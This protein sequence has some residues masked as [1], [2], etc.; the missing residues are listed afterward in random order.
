MCVALLAVAA[1]AGCGSAV[2][3]QASGSD[4]R[5]VVRLATAADLTPPTLFAGGASNRILIGQVYETLVT[6]P[7][8]GLDPQPAL[9]TS[10]KLAPDG[11]SISLELR[12]NVEFSN[13]VEFT[14]KDVEASIKA[15]AEPQWTAQMLLTAA[16]ITGFESSNPHQ[17]T[18]RFA[19]PLSN[20]FDLLDQVPM[21][22]AKSIDQVAAGKAFIG[23]GPFVLASWTPNSKLVF[24]PNDRYW[25][26]PPTIDEVV[27]MVGVDSQSQVAQLRAGQLD[28]ILDP[29]SRE[30]DQ[31][32]SDSQFQVLALNGTEQQTYLGM[33]VANAALK[34]VRLREAIALAID[35]QRIADDVYGGSAVPISLPWPKYSP[36]YSAQQNAAFAQDIP[37][38]KKL[39]AEIGDV[40]TLPIQYASEFPNSAELAQIIQADLKEI[41]VS[42][43][44]EP[45]QLAQFAGLLVEGKFSAL[46][47]INHEFAQ[48]TPSTLAVSAYPFNAEKNASNFDSPEYKAAANGA[49][50]LTDSDGPEAKKAYARLDDA[51]LKG[52]FLT[53]LVGV[54]PRVVAA[55]DV[56]GITWGK[57]SPELHLAKVSFAD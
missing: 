50:E 16:A 17:I 14:A 31:L 2:E 36:A 3:Q 57:R 48:F 37:T 24:R 1:A 20:I 8:E 19:H 10:W 13:G 33:N 44:L 29:E 53:E 26:D 40:P 9:A 30:I 46:W 27:L 41:G 55:A 6:Y 5:G 39:V 11:K 23:T 47:V 4:D 54:T 32:A 56:E 12:P 45:L 52:L 22:E 43:K 15:Y 25:G 28:V 34:D 42:T 51:L 18:L 7:A 35:R 49:W 38:A 21:L